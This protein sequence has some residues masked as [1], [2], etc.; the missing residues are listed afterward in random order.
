MEYASK[1][2]FRIVLRGYAECIRGRPIYE[3]IIPSGLNLIDHANRW[4][5]S[6][7]WCFCNLRL[8]TIPWVAFQDEIN[9]FQAGVFALLATST[10]RFDNAENRILMSLLRRLL[11]TRIHRT[12]PT[13]QF[14]INLEVLKSFGFG[15]SLLEARFTYLYIVWSFHFGN[16]DEFFAQLLVSSMKVSYDILSVESN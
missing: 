4:K 5:V 16:L 11:S 8:L 3:R 1:V 7:P 12:L 14:S 2:L 6:N 13:L 15:A 10:L 9:T